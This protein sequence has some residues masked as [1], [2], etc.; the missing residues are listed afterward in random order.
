MQRDSEPHRA[1][2]EKIVFYIE[3]GKGPSHIQSKYRLGRIIS[4][5]LYLDPY[6]ALYLV[7]KG[8][9]TAENPSM[10]SLL[11]LIRAFDQPPG[12]TDRFYLFQLL[13]SKGFQVKVEN[14]SM[15]YR[16]TPREAYM[17]PVTTVREDRTISFSQLASG[18][19]SLY[20]AIDDDHD[21]TMFIA[22]RFEPEGSVR[23]VLGGPVTIVDLKGTPAS[24]DS[25]IP[26]WMGTTIGNIRL[27]NEYESALL[28]GT[29]VDNE[30]LT[31]TVFRDL[32]ARGFIVRTGF[33]YGANFRVYGVN[34]D[35]HAEFL[36]HVLQETEEWYKISRAV[37]VAQGVRKEMVFAGKSGSETAY[38][39]IIRVRD[40]FLNG[41][42]IWDSKSSIE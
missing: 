39:K 21:I 41:D 20:A 18:N 34:I 10:R 7:I 22:R 32:V 3:D 15:Y 40:P 2:C 11:S 25:G 28:S 27:L 38:V 35:A 31:M 9:I 36:V 24:E 37:R 33:K 6:E 42:Q 29:E 4:G 30:N 12:F 17:G 1:I 5:I 16:K 8:R 23:T 13:K 26:D 19:D 14:N